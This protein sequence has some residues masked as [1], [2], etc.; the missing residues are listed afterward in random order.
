MIIMRKLIL[1]MLLFTACGNAMAEWVKVG[2]TDYF[3]LYVDKTTIVKISDMTNMW[4]LHD[5]KANRKTV[6]NESYRST[7]ELIQYNCKKNMMRTLSYSLHSKKMG[8][9]NVIYQDKF[10][11]NWTATKQNS[12]DTTLWK[13]ACGK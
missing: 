12:I 13:I 11:G 9:G 4:H 2:T 7:K 5:E 3:D 6:T 8:E 1:M 10:A